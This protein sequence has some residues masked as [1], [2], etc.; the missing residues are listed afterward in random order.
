MLQQCLPSEGRRL[1]Q[2]PDAVS[3]AGVRQ[4]VGAGGKPGLNFMPASCLP[5]CWPACRACLSEDPSQRPTM[6]EVAD[7]FATWQ[8]HA[9]KVTNLITNCSQEMH[10][11]I[12]FRRQLGPVDSAVAARGNILV[13]GLTG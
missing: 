4:L 13:G 12:S 7:G 5:L 3:H 8:Y 10:N 1:P 9:A 6:S 11:C 2:D